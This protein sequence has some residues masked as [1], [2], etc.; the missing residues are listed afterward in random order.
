[1]KRPSYDLLLE[2]RFRGVKCYW[3]ITTPRAGTMTLTSLLE[4]LIYVD[5]AHEPFPELI[6]EGARAIAG[7]PLPEDA[8]VRLLHVARGRSVEG[9]FR[10]AD[11]EEQCTGS[12]FDVTCNMSHLAEDIKAAFADAR[13]LHLIREPREFVCS[14]LGMGFFR[15]EGKT[16][17]YWP[18]P[19]EHCRE[20]WQWACWYWG[21]VHRKGLDLESMWGPIT[22]M[23]LRSEDLFGSPAGFERLVGWMDKD[24]IDHISRTRGGTYQVLG[25]HK[26]RAR[27]PKPDWDSAWDGYLEDVAGDVIDE[28]YGGIC[29]AS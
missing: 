10:R 1:M 26:N 18:G 3:T 21:T 19:P 5:A 23:R 7:D 8:A 16:A 25:Q 2:N 24:S 9:S 27:F 22:V 11:L 14:A 12:Y 4:N 20:P 29:V 28:V 17:Y 13:F 15:L 6:P